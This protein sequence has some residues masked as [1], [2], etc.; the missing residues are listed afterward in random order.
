MVEEITKGIKVS[1]ETQYNGTSSKGNKLYY[2]FSYFVTI[3]NN[4]TKTVELTHRLWRIFD[5]LNKTEIVEGEGVVGQTP[6]LKPNQAYSYSSGCFLGSNAGAM[7]GYY[8]MKN[9]LND[10]TFRV[11]IPTFQLQTLELLN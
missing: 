10:E 3:E 1:V 8:K 6:L 11:K 2:V 5:S 4:S 7:C 9:I